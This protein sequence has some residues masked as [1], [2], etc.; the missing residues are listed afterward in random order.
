MWVWVLEYRVEGKN[1]LWSYL[2]SIS[3]HPQLWPDLHHPPI[4]I[5]HAYS[6]SILSVTVCQGHIWFLLFCWYLVLLLLFLHL[7]L[8][9]FGLL[10]CFCFCIPV[11]IRGFGFCGVS[12]LRQS[13]GGSQCLKLLMG[14]RSDTDRDFYLRQ[15]VIREIAQQTSLWGNGKKGLA[16]PMASK[17]L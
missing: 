12:E 15:P 3:D 10:S 11:P 5:L 6:L 2:H 7:L 4:S 8:F 13:A 17:K 16:L 1:L 14:I 9:W